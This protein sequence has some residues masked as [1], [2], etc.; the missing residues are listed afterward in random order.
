MKNTNNSQCQEAFDRLIT[1]IR[2][3]YKTAANLS[4]LSKAF[5]A[6]MDNTTESDNEHLHRVLRNLKVAQDLALLQCE[7]SLLACAILLDVPRAISRELR[8]KGVSE[9]LDAYDELSRP[10]KP[11]GDE[12]QLSD[13]LY[14][15]VQLHCAKAHRE[16][17]DGSEPTMYNGVFLQGALI[18]AAESMKMRYH[19]RLLRND[20]YAKNLCDEQQRSYVDVTTSIQTLNSV[21]KDAYNA[22][23]ALMLD[24]LAM[25]SQFSLVSKDN[26]NSLE[27]GITL[28]NALSCWDVK[29][30]M[31]K[32]GTIE[33]GMLDLWEVILSYKGNDENSMVRDYIAF[34]REYLSDYLTVQ[35]V[36]K[37]DHCITFRLT[38]MVENNYILKL[39]PQSKL[40]SYYLG[41]ECNADVTRLVYDNRNNLP[42]ITVYAMEDDQYHKIIMPTGA[43]VLDMAFYVNPTDAVAVTGARIRQMVAESPPIFNDNDHRYPLHTL[44]KENDVVSFDALWGNSSCR[45]SHASIDWFASINTDYAKVCLIKYLKEKYQSCD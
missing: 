19:V 43:T 21:S 35:Y 13:H 17:Q 29:E 4:A 11:S 41:N 10:N 26:S 14:H 24:T 3:H 42:C 39:I 15:A 9:I 12:H 20:C 33:R 38:D 27:S 22:F 37:K 31:D 18:P 8:L 28:R 6:A 34:H 23:D 44:L 32:V 5:E 36:G 16:L 2:S 1:Y 45:E 30:Q 25:Q 7:T 40:R